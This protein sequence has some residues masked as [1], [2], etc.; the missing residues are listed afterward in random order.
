V[1]T[2]GKPIIACSNDPLLGG[3]PGLHNPEDLLIST[4]ASCHMLWYLHLSFN[5]G[6]IVTGYRD[7]PEG[8]GQSEPSGAGRFLKAI[9]RPQISLTPGQDTT[10]ADAV[11]S[12]IHAVC[13]IAQSVNFPIEIEASYDIEPS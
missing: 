5:A 10:A 13:F 6:I 12:R 2:P 1:E 3:D 11:H 8:V 7:T 4:I 9:L